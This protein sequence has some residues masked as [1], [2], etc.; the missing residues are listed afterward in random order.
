M[1]DLKEEE[2]RGGE[3]REGEK[4]ERVFFRTD[5]D[6]EAGKCEEEDRKLSIPPYA[7]SI[8]IS[9]ARSPGKHLS[10]VPAGLKFGSGGKSGFLW[11]SL[12]CS[13]QKSKLVKRNKQSM[14]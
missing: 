12:F 13:N 8:F 9:A 1:G 7:D 11:A 14:P 10:Q 3:R 4:A 5:S 6:A 2:G